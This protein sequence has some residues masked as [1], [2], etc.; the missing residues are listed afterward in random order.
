MRCIRPM[1]LPLPPRIEVRFR[2]HHGSHQVSGRMTRRRCSIAASLCFQFTTPNGSGGAP[3]L[4]GFGA[5]SQRWQLVAGRG[6][7]HIRC[8]TPGCLYGRSGW[9][10]LSAS[11]SGWNS[12]TQ[13]R[14]FAVTGNPG[15]GGFAR[16][17]AQA[18]AGPL[19]RACRRCIHVNLAA[20]FVC[21]R[22]NAVQCSG[23]A[24]PSGTRIRGRIRVCFRLLVACGGRSP[25]A[26]GSAA[27]IGTAPQYIH[28]SSAT[29][30]RAEWPKPD[31][32]ISRALATFGAPQR[33]QGSGTLRLPPTRALRFIYIRRR[34][35]SSPAGYPTQK[36][37]QNYNKSRVRRPRPESCRL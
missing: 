6:T 19:G 24:V 14:W 10:R 30:A 18:R 7:G 36:N 4:W 34:V 32:M 27:Q 1:A 21:N 29:H 25:T 15:G 8:R 9:R 28:T 16:A 23:I 3:G 35:Y 22:Q 37:V 17:V 2:P 13:A 33:N 26:S 12:N 11:D 31:R 20:M 5:M